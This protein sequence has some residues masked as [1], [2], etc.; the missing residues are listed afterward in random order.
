MYYPQ[1]TPREMGPTSVTPRSQYITARD[2]DGE[3]L[4]TS[5]PAGTVALI[6]YD[7]LHKKEANYTD[8]TRH[9]VKFLFTRMTEPTEPTWDHSYETW[10]ASDDPQE[11]TYQAMWD[12]HLGKAPEHASNGTSIQTLS[13]QLANPDEAAALHASY[14]LGLQ[15]EKAVPAMIDA[16]KETE[17][18]NR[19]RNAGYGFT[20][21]GEVAVPALIELTKN[22][23][24]KIRMRAVDVLG[25]LGLRA[26]S[27]TPDL[28]AL[29]QDTDEDTRAH[30]AES[31]GTTSQ[32]TSEATRPL[33]DILSTDE[34]DFVRRQ[35]RPL[36]RAIGHPCRRSHSRIGRRHARW[37]PLRPRI[38]RT[39]P[40]SHR[41]A[42]SS[43]SRHASPPGTALGQ[44]TQRTDTKK[45]QKGS[46]RDGLEPRDQT[47]SQRLLRKTS[48]PTTPCQKHPR[49]Q[50]ARQ[51]WQNLNGLWDYALESIGTTSAPATYQGQILVP[52]AID[53][54]LSGI[55]EILRPDQRLWYRRNITLPDA[56]TGKRVT[57]PFPGIRLG[58]LCLC[59]RRE[60][61]DNTAADTIP[62][63]LT[64]PTI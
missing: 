2:Q 5:G 40:L 15:G 50:M 17:D 46:L 36:P 34:S 27:A 58:N 55:M 45:T 41:H 63:P 53:A 21:V 7:I 3:H 8:I 26:R 42:R 31:L 35:R 19:P 29:L 25:D 14:T 60:K 23:D 64:S 61:R 18:E 49:P 16:L 6:H 20:N 43:Q 32:N 51:H 39:R 10:I 28:I 52:F 24:P 4:F 13:E 62:L 38:C 11:P 56:W 9:M 12:W 33:A 1:D 54:P 22:P 47:P 30:A 37:Q 57:P 44:R 59:Q 48:P